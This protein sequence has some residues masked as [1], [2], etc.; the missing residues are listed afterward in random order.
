MLYNIKWKVFCWTFR[1]GILWEG[2]LLLFLG[3]YFILLL[4]E[5]L[6]NSGASRFFAAYYVANVCLIASYALVRLW[7]LEHS[8]LSH[9]KFSQNE[10][11]LSKVC[12]SEATIPKFLSPMRCHESPLSCRSPPVLRSFFTGAAGIQSPL[13]SNRHQVFQAT[14]HGWIFD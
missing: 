2:L 6:G 5:M 8:D 7:F 3:Q 13:N 14:V 1:S 11:L 10:Q 9:S 4:G 12:W